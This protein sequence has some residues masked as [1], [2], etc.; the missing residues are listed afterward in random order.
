M[1]R[2]ITDIQPIRAFESVPW[3]NFS[4]Q[5]TI[6]VLEDANKN[7][8]IRIVA[9]EKRLDKLEKQNI[10]IKNL[11]MI[12]INGNTPNRMIPHIHAQLADLFNDDEKKDKVNKY[13]YINENE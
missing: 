8:K 12:L 6:N 3:N 7:L 1:P 10:K 2:N 4:P 5:L 11:F 9:L 13:K